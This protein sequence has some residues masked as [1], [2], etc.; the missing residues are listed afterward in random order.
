MKETSKLKELSKILDK[1]IEKNKEHPC[2]NC[3]HE[4]EGSMVLVCR[5]LIEDLLK[6]VDS[7]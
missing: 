3:I 2:A 4:S 5:K 7:L 6:E 1:C